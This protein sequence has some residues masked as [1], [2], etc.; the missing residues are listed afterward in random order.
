MMW[1][2]VDVR[3]GFNYEISRR[4]PYRAR[5][6]MWLEAGKL[7]PLLR[8]VEMALPV[9]SIYAD[10]ASDRVVQSAPPRTRP[11]CRSSTSHRASSTPWRA[12]LR[13]GTGSWKR[14][15]APHRRLRQQPGGYEEGDREAAP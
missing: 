11:S 7:E 9:D 5:G 3:G 13:R 2:R 10:M 15:T 12:S 8:S 1:H 4:A 6:R 14:W